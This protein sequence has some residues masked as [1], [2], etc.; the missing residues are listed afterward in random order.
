MIQTTFSRH[1]NIFF[2]G[3][4][5]Q[6]AQQVYF[7]SILLSNL[8]SNDFFTCLRVITPYIEKLLHLLKIGPI[9]N[10]MLI[11]IYLKWTQ[12]KVKPVS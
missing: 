5:F 10:L 9:P 4:I 12:I 2:W 7:K 1:Q 3:F 8:S 11:S 6:D